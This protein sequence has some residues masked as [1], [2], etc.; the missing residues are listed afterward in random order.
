MTFLY[1]QVFIL[2]LLLFWIFKKRQKS[3]NVHKICKNSAETKEHSWILYLVLGLM[4]LALSRPVILEQKSE[5]EVLGKAFIIALDVSYSMRAED[6]KPNRITYAKKKIETLFKKHPHERFSLFAFT[7]NP[8]ILSPSTSDHQL[9]FAALGSL[10]VENILT[11]GTNLE[12]LFERI[13]KLQSEEKNLLLISDG[14][15]GQDIAPLLAL[16]NK[17]N[18]SVF[19]M[20]MATMSGSTLSDRYGKKLKDKE[21]NLVITKLNPLLKQLAEQSGGAFVDHAGEFDL[22]LI[23]QKALSQKAK[24]GYL[25]LYWIPLLAALILFW[26]FFVRFPKKLLALIPFL[27]LHSE[28]GI[29]D[30]YY[31]GKAADH[32]QNRSYQEA[33]INYEKVSFKTLQSQMNLANSYY[34]AGH[35]KRAQSIYKTLRTRDGALKKRIF[36]KLGNCAAKLKAYDEAK[37]YY[38]F[39]LAFEKDEDIVYNL[40]MIAD[41]TSKQRRDFPAFKSEDIAR[42]DTPK[43]LDKQQKEQDGGKMQ[44]QSGVN[45]AAGQSS[46]AQ[47]KELKQRVSPSKLTRPLGYKAYE[48]INQGYID[49]TNPW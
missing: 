49:E 9:L 21:G 25:E 4:I 13:G 20:G 23:R 44:T 35:Y 16:C 8:L 48:L 29:L 42:E 27:A 18:I 33:A 17:H 30:W 10:R 45:S 1:P 11:H 39:A 36:Y 34:Q 2:L 31:I 15:D 14:G 24:I 43:G 37:R 26:L 40:K 22:D 19:A 28:A 3:F 6:L 38:R 41:K 46:D 47:S 12:K 32:Y 7:T 5:E